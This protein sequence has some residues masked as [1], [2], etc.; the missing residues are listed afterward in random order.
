MSLVLSALLGYVGAMVTQVT[1]DVI[2]SGS[3]ARARRRLAARAVDGAQAMTLPAGSGGV[4]E[5]LD[6][7]QLRILRDFLHGPAFAQVVRQ[8]LVVAARPGS[9]EARTALRDQVRHGL[10]HTGAFGPDVRFE[11]TDLV[12]HLVQVAV[13]DPDGARGELDAHTLAIGADVAAAGV[14]NADLLHRLDSLVEIDGFAGALREAARAQHTRLRLH[15][16]GESRFVDYSALYVAPN[17]RPQAEPDADPSTVEEVVAGGL[18]TVVLGDPGAGK[19]TLAAKLVHDIAA[20]RAPGLEGLVPLLLVVREHTAGLRHRHDTLVS[21]LEAICRRPHHLVPPPDALEYLLLNG[22]AL[23]VIDGLDELGTAQHRRSFARMVEGFVHRYPLTRILLTSRVVGYAEAPL[24]PELFAVTVVAP[25][26]D[27]QI[28]EYVTKWFA[29]DPDAGRGDLASDFLQESAGARDLCANPLMLSLLCTLYS[30]THYIPRNRPEIYERCAELLF[31]TWDQ[32]RDIAVPHRYS[33]FVRPTVQRLAWQ[34]FTDP[35]GRQVLPRAELSRSLAEHLA[36]RR[37]EDPDEALQAAEDFLD[38]CAGR[39]WVLTDMGVDRAQPLYGF[40]HR[41]FLEYF[42]ASQLV[43]AR[44]DPSAVWEQIRTRLLDVTWNVVAQLAVQILDRTCEGGAD[45]VLRLAVAE[46]D[47]AT[48]PERALLALN[49]AVKVLEDVAPGNDVVRDVVTRA[50]L[51]ACA[52]DPVRRVARARVLDFEDLP[53]GAALHVVNPDNRGRVTQG[54]VSAVE[55]ATGD[56]EA[57][58]SAGV[59]RASLV[60]QGLFGAFSRSGPLVSRFAGRLGAAAPEPAR[61]WRCLELPSA[62]SLRAGGFDSLFDH[63][64]VAWN[65]SFSQAEWILQVLDHGPV[66]HRTDTVDHLAAL[67]PHLAVHFAPIRDTTRSPRMPEWL[68]GPEAW[69]GLPPQARAALMLVIVGASTG[70][71]YQVPHRACYG[72]VVRARGNTSLRPAGHG[73]LR[74]LGLPDDAHAVLTDW[75]EGRI[76]QN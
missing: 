48:D 60:G 46:C 39:A 74:E 69:S 5:R 18:R 72:A 8:A 65:T 44:P 66:E 41:T 71:N 76:T 2:H 31:V 12:L 15:H 64:S 35:A 45:D 61:W 11:V 14:R 75:I 36:V 54:I 73:T 62:G 19:S 70:R 27:R 51:R 68:N 30:S 16:A 24:E 13:H 23:V 55:A 53:L 25:F 1:G 28:T 43:K 26:A 40:V 4:L 38:F 52:M 49:F 10:R 34:L 37:F 42:A 6:A 17:L 63:V 22:R 47:T 20:D 7:E 32:S 67:A 33:A 29:L 56:P 59:V 50:V 3:A 58:P 57:F 21:Y 9:E